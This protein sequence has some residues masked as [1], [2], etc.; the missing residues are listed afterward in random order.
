MLE[1]WKLEDIL[2]A[3]GHKAEAYI[4]AKAGRAHNKAFRQTKGNPFFLYMPLTAPHTPIA[5]D[6]ASRGRSQAGGIAELTP[7]AW[8]S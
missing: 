8:K 5:P 2:P 1:G 7:S 3:L 6:A 4:D